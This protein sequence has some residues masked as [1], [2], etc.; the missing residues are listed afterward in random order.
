MD[1]RSS[2]AGLAET[3][4][5][6]A[7]SGCQSAGES[8]VEPEPAPEF[9]SEAELEPEVDANPEHEAKAEEPPTPDW[10]VLGEAAYHG[11]A[12][13]IVRTIEPH[14]EG[15]PVAILI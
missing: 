9:E 11:L 12:G 10:P 6:R 7:L 15:D 5:R 4:I 2:R 14:T 8:E 1:S 3:G 13:K